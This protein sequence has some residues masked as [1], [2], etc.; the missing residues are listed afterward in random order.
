MPRAKAVEEK[1]EFQLEP[2]TE[3]TAVHRVRT[4]A[5]I[6]LTADGGL[7]E[8]RLKEDTRQKIKEFFTDPEN[9]RKLGLKE[10][11]AGGALAFA[12][13][14]I[15]GVYRTLGQVFAVTQALLPPKIPYSFAIK[16]C[17][18]S[19]QELDMLRQPT[20]GSLVYLAKKYP[21]LFKVAECQE[22]VITATLLF[23]FSTQKFK[24]TR[25]AWAKAGQ[26]LP[27][28]NVQ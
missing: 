1:E 12:D 19:E 4:G 24:Q 23:V 14:F 22:L 9:L 25:E 16:Y 8:N 27:S 21:W 18:F 20:K 2:S 17:E 13:G 5:Y 28:G 15:D 3:K 26:E 10:E 7:D 6:P 11:D